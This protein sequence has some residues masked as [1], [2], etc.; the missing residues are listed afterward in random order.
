VPPGA[1]ELGAELF[2]L[3]EEKL[4]PAIRVGT[5]GARDLKILDLRASAG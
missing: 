2:I 5:H 4:L 1:I 3:E